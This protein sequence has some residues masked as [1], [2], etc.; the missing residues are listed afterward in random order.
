MRKS[1]IIAALLTA[2]L[3]ALPVHAPSRHR[4]AGLPAKIALAARCSPDLTP[5]Q[6]VQ[7][8]RPGVVRLHSEELPL[9]RLGPRLES[10]FEN[11]VQRVVFIS[12]D[13]QL[14]FSDVAAVFDIALQHADYVSLITPNV[15][16][17]LATEPGNCLD[18]NIK[19]SKILM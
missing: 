3:L 9:A 5:G 12:A 8:L 14:S 2:I 18:P 16:H 10:I 6:V 11:S 15:E 13:S 19:F 17:T 7:V 1:T 4:S